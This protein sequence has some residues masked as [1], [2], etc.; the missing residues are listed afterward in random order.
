MR[1]ARK[2]TAAE[3]QQHSAINGNTVEAS[4]TNEELIAEFNHYQSQLGTIHQV[5]ATLLG[6]N[7]ATYKRYRN[8][9]KPLHPDV[10]DKIRVLALSKGT[11]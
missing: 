2:A 9:K 3:L 5:T 11:I 7:Y 1:E 6:I 10:V 8:G 4:K